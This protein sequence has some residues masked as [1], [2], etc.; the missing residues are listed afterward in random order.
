MKKAEF[1]AADKAKRMFWPTQGTRGKTFD[2]TRCLAAGI[3]I[4][5][6]ALHHCGDVSVNNLITTLIFEFTF[7][8]TYPLIAVVIGA[9]EVT[10]QPAYSIF[11]CSP[12]SSGTWRILCL[13]IPWCYLPTSFPVHLVFFPLSLCLAWWLW[14]DLMNRRYIHTTSVCIS[15]WSSGGHRVVQL[16]AGSW[17]GLSSLVTWSL[18]EMCSILR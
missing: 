4:S 12:L 13:S 16:P 18:Y 8:F 1:L 17:H 6:S 3:L 9:L 5:T 15:L 7:T 2:S 11:P 10:P 14:P